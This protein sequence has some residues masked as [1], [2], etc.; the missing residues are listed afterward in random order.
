MT[1]P[2][3]DTE[4]LAGATGAPATTDAVTAPMVGDVDSDHIAGGP[5]RRGFLFIFWLAWFGGS[6]ASGT[7][8]GAALPKLLAFMDESTKEINLSIASAIG[9][10]IV[11][12]ITP[13]FGRLSDRTMSPLGIRRPWLIG[14]LAGA[15]V[16]AAVFSVSTNL[17]MVIIALCIGQ[18][19]FGAVNMVYH[20]LIADQIPKR[21]RARTAGILGVGGSIALLL[22][23]QLIGFLPNDQRWLWFMIPAVVG[24]GMSA[25]LAIL[26]KDIVR[27]E[28][29]P[30][31]DL[32]AIL[33][34]YWLNP[35]KYRNFAWA[36]GCRLFVT[37]SIVSVAG[38]LLYYIIDVLGIPK[39]DASKLYAN[40]LIVFSIGNIVMTL[41][42]GWISDRTGRRKPIV[43][44]S[45][46]LS[47]IGLLILLLSHD[48]TT[49]WIALAIVGAAQ[50]AFISVDIAL[51]TE[52]L[53][54]FADAGKDLG[55]VALSYQVPQLLVPL[56]AIPLLSIGGGQNYEALYTAALVFGVLGAICVLPIK[57]VK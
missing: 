55:I 5:Q 16:A 39:E 22:G 15:M 20:A 33:S 29:G 12:I 35:V 3:P 19:A 41:L 37:M 14:G 28:P 54:S 48:L 30:P 13:L 17:V 40:A 26:L 25:L 38:Y 50:G 23:A 52:V 11:M 6:F 43:L 9:G 4:I 51:M 44:I 10:V 34:T 56:I 53:P 32:K 7:I 45:C 2:L 21:I 1:D 8:S 31:L 49:F 27:T 24:C 46:V 57:G 47:A 18:I 36:W 42:F